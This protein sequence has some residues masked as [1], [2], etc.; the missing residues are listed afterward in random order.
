VRLPVLTL[1]V[2]L[3]SCTA[4]ADV[5]GIKALEQTFSTRVYGN[6][7][8]FP[9]PEGLPRR[10]GIQPMNEVRTIT[11]TT[12][13]S[14]SVATTLGGYATAVAGTFFVNAA[15]DASDWPI[16]VSHTSGAMAHYVLDFVPLRD[17]VADLTAELHPGGGVSYID[18]FL[19]LVNLTTN[20]RL[21]RV[22]WETDD[23]WRAYWY[24][25]ARWEWSNWQ[26]PSPYTSASVSL[27]SSDTYRLTMYSRV[28]NMGDGQRASLGLTGLTIVPEPTS[29][30]LLCVGAGLHFMLSRRRRIQA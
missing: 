12:P 7:T 15:G 4:A 11:S 28:G 3:W 25:N 23:E 13:I 18:V 29:L 1:A 5:I 17:G 16:A 27:L 8:V 24:D 20:E 26:V 6:V 2:C 10:E 19:E 30:T 14:D 22:G 9:K 21:L